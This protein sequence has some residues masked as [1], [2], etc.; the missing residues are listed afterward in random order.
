[1]RIRQKKAAYLFDNAENLF[2]PERKP[3]A[4]AALRLDYEI[5]LRI[6][7]FGEKCQIGWQIFPVAQTEKSKFIRK[8]FRKV[9]LNEYCEF[10]F[11]FVEERIYHLLITLKSKTIEIPALSLLTC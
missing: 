5:N 4:V 11:P 10:V 7:F 1:M 3:I 8:N 6:E 9:F 2:H